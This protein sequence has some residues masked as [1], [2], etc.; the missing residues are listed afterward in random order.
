MSL[1]QK[2]RTSN[3]LFQNTSWMMLSEGLA[4]LSRIIT[5]IA[6]ASLLAPF[7]YGIATLALACH[8]I[9]RVFGRAGSGARVIQCAQ[10]ELERISRN[11][12]LLQWL[13]CGLITVLQIIFS[14][15]IADFYQHPELAP[16]L[17]IMALTYLFYPMVSIK[18]FMLQRL[19]RMKYFG[20]ANAACISIDN[21]AIV[22]F[23]ALGHGVF[24]VA[25]AK[26]LTA[27]A[28]VLLFGL[29]NVPS[30]RPGYQAHVFWPLAAYSGKIFGSETLRVLRSQADVLIA[31]R[32][33]SP[34]LMGLYSFAKNAGVGLGQSLINA[35]LSGLY[36]Y[37]CEQIRQG[38]AQLAARKSILYALAIS[39]VFIAQALAAPI[40][41]PL[42]FGD[43]WQGAA[44]LVTILCLSA[45][46]ALLVDT[47][48]FFYRANNRPLDETK[49]TLVCVLITVFTLAIVAP[50]S[51]QTLALCTTLA[52][53]S[54]LVFIAR[55]L[56]Q[57]LSNSAS[58]APDP[59]VRISL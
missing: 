34:E 55:F 47:R 46:P 16:L 8:E 22:C 28:W 54:W 20:L 21:L 37:I 49:L 11:A 25:Y 35:F 12:S 14:R 17:S 36:P 29:A 56:L 9:I 50:E 52:S 3:R 10:H 13:V 5:V 27:C 7:D 57:N 38:N 48:A 19:N 6:M 39:S 26:V 24:A 59:L 44:Y 53:L 2:F 41:V 4:K 32:L 30:A 51:P 40:Y 23:L 42:L 31:G 1:L 58:K 45:I 43:L 18:I 33:L 15:V